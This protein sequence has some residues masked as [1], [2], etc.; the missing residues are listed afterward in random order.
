M[1]LKIQPDNR[2]LLIEA[3]KV[4]P[5]MWTLIWVFIHHPAS[6][7]LFYQLFVPFFPS[8][9]FQVNIFNDS[10]LSLLLDVNPIQCIFHL[11]H[12]IFYFRSSIWISFYL[13]FLPNVPVLSSIFVNVIGHICNFKKCLCVLILACFPFLCLF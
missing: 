11:G 13:K 6:F 5:W 8:A 9:F 3:F 2:Y 7:Y 10:I 1:L 12:S 4:I